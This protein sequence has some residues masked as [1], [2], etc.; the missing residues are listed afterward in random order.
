MIHLGISYKIRAKEN[1]AITITMNGDVKFRNQ[2][3]WKSLD[4]EEVR[5]RIHQTQKGLESEIIRDENYQNVKSKKCIQRL[6]TVNSF[7]IY[8]VKVMHACD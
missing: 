5:V 3:S 4:L 1:C 2:H 6:N 8:L 7:E